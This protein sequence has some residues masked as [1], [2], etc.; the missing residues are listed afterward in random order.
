MMLLMTIV[1]DYNMSPV[2][3]TMTEMMENE[4]YEYKKI[5]TA[6]PVCKSVVVLVARKTLAEGKVLR[7]QT[8]LHTQVWSVHSYTIQRALIRKHV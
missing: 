6:A 2:Y 3:E 8:V 1:D 4:D 5:S 7:C